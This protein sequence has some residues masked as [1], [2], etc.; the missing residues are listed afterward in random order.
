M[1]IREANASN[2]AEL[3][4]AQ[5]P[6]TVNAHGPTPLAGAELDHVAAAGGKGGASGGDV[7]CRRPAGA[8]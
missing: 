8:Q 4:T 3:S 7:R 2:T 5:T 6:A 1:T